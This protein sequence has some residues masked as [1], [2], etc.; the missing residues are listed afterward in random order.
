MTTKQEKTLIDSGTAILYGKRT[1]DAQDAHPILVDAY[2]GLVGSQGLSHK[3]Q[4]IAYTAAG[5]MEY[6]G[7]AEKGAA[8][9]DTSWLLH[10]L[11]Y[12]ASG[13]QTK[14]TI[15]YDSWDNYLTATY[16]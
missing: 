5:L 10:K 11:E 6:V 8:E 3:Q 13:Q 12:N 14:R 4:R 2:G 16:S 1:A 9:S 15:A 7:E